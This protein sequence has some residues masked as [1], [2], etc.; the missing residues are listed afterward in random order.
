MSF[1][2]GSRAAKKLLISMRQCGAQAEVHAVSEC[3]VAVG[4]SGDVES[5]RITEGVAV[6]VGRYVGQQ[7]GVSLGDGHAAHGGVVR[8]GAHECLDWGDPADHFFGGQWLQAGV[9]AQCS[10]LVGVLDEGVQA[11]GD[12]GAGGVVAGRGGAPAHVQ[13]V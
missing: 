3:E 10:V 7:Q 12:G 4:V 9:G 11:A 1:R 6:A 13:C 5:E 2:R 8:G